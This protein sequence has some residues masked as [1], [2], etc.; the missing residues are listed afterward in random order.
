VASFSIVAPLRFTCFQNNSLMVD[1]RVPKTA[2][3]TRL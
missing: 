1:G 3:V 2:L